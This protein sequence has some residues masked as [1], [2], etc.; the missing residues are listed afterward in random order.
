MSSGTSWKPS[1]VTLADGREVLSD[2]TEWMQECEARHV[3]NLPTKAA[4]HSLLDVI[5]KKRGPE[6]RKALEDR[7]MTLWKLGRTKGAA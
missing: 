5:E 6:A 4:R 3:L 1:I 2:S 7:I